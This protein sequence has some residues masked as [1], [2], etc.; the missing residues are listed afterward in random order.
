MRFSIRTG[1]IIGLFAAVQ[2]CSAAAPLPLPSTPA[3]ATSALS[4]LPA[5][6]AVQGAYL[7]LGDS[8]SSG[9]GAYPAK[10][11]LAPANRCHRTSASYVHTVRRTFRFA[12]GT[13]FWACAGARVDHLLTGKSGE[14][15]QLDRA[16]ARTSLITLTIGGNDLGFSQV[17]AACA[18]PSSRACAQEEAA[19]PARRAGLRRSLDALLARLTA[20]APKARIILVGYPRLF[21]PEIRGLNTQGDRLNDLLRAAARRAD[22]ALVRR[23]AAGSVEYADTAAA[24]AGH[25]IGAQDPYVNGLSLT[26]RAGMFHPNAAG[27]RALARA[28]VRQIRTG[29]DRPLS[30]R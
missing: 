23:R 15:P 7:A 3:P 30:P 29:P 20:R 10:A 24:F 19:L 18:L 22:S 6:L 8:Y 11:D 4:P 1:L 27:Y 2:G 26:A 16:G 14:A 5:A 25:E 13:S 9:E 12:G 17:I 28:V 21:A